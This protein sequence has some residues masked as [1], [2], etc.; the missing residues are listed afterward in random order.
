VG[1][2]FVALV[3]LAPL[4]A[5]AMP[6]LSDLGPF[7]VPGNSADLAQQRSANAQ[8]LTTD[9]AAKIESG[10]LERVGLLSQALSTKTRHTDLDLTAT[11]SSPGLPIDAQGRLYVRI[12]GADAGRHTDD[13]IAQGALPAAMAPGFDFLEA[14]V[15]YDRV[16]AVSE[17]PWVRLVALPGMACFDVGAKTTEGDTILRAAQARTL[18]GI[19]GTGASVGVI[20]DGVNSF[21]VAQ[22]T[23]DLPGAL[24]IGNAG[25]G[26]EGTAMLEIVHDLAPG[27]ALAFSS[28]VGGSAAMIASQNYLVS[29][30]GANIV[31]DDVWLPREPYF[32]DG[33]V[34]QNASTLVTTKNVVYFTSAGNRAQ[35]HVQQMFKDGG[36]RAIGTAG[37]FRPHDFG[38]G[39]YTLDIRLRNPSGTGV[40]HTIVLQ[41]GEKFGTAAKNFDLYLLDGALA[42]V[43][44]ASTTVQN[45]AGDPVELIDFTYSGPDNA[46]AALVVDFNSGGAAPSNMPLKILANGP[47]FL[48]SVT[49]AGSV[50]Q[51]AGSP[52]VIALGA[53]DQADPGADDAEAFSSRGPTSILFPAPA[54]RG[55]PDAMAIDDVSVTGAGGFPTPFTGTSA[56][57]PHG[58][59]LAAL[60]RGAKPLLTA[61]VVK[62]G[63]LSTAVDLGT[64]GF[65]N[66]TGF[67]RLDAI[68]FLAPFFDLPPV[69]DA[70]NDTTVECEGP[71]GTHVRLDGSRS[72]DPN[73][74]PLVF[75]WLPPAGVTFDDVHAVKPLGTFPFGV[76]D[77]S[78][79]VFDGVFADTDTV[80]VTIAD[81]KPP[82]VTVTLDPST[83]WPPNH[84][85]APITATVTVTDVC[86]PNPAVTLLSITSNEPD[87]G[88]GDGDTPGDIQDADVG[89]DDRSFLLR[90]ERS[91]IAAGRVYTVCYQAKDEAG[92][93]GIGCATVTVTHDQSLNAAYAPALD[94]DLTTWDSGGWITLDPPAGSASVDPTSLG[95][96]LGSDAFTRVGAQRSLAGSSGP[97]QS[98]PGDLAGTP[99]PNPWRWAL[100]SDDARALLTGA[101]TPVVSLRVTDATGHSYLAQ[102][103]LPN[104][105]TA[106]LNAA[107]LARS[108]PP[109][110]AS[111]VAGTQVGEALAPSVLTVHATSPLA[112]GG[113]L[114]FG[115]PR[116]GRARLDLVSVV[117]R[118]VARLDSGDFAAGWYE[119]RIPADVAPG[120]Y[121]A[122][123]ATPFGRAAKRFVLVR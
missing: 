19:D 94:T 112:P 59:G 65:D 60:L 8:A 38:G 10:V 51:E 50:N 36:V 15:P 12:D 33:P 34:A 69:A 101:G 39:D 62:T 11:Y 72:S 7:L 13:L 117:G 28:G 58:A 24:T 84:I 27:A 74:D 64:P 70:G 77:V 116:A 109:P 119:A 97:I 73:N 47:T 96:Q 98:L 43:L 37:T 79:V 86:D 104:V 3:F 82:V 41:W 55:K 115:L 48:Q 95:A 113:T 99:V 17:L 122:R 90:S 110:P 120:V 81:T 87:N 103:T 20:S 49:P 26:D 32:E 18:F 30:V 40:R 106:V 111:S 80:R 91:G 123:L 76:W 88:L 71:A 16:F 2:G 56:A 121:F 118:V 100:S 1:L 85:L 31:T 105:P 108:T 5:R 23:G 29:V 52:D 66:T 22:G 46:P 14:W 6:R 25:S 57:S 35:R 89:T 61:A 63:L 114:R 68:N 54:T 102:V 93:V 9:P 67:G 42:N 53:I 83:L 21:G 4:P 78:L 44:Q 75:T 45:G 107:P 92:N